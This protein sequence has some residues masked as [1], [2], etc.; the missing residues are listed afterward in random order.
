[1]AATQP[2]PQNAPSSAAKEAAA[3]LA[4]HNKST[5]RRTRT[6]AS[7]APARQSGSVPGENAGTR[8]G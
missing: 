4:L 7:W 5:E 6:P 3:V 8:V 1:M 2:I